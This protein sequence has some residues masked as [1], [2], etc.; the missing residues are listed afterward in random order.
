MIKEV[1]QRFSKFASVG[2]VCT[3]FSLTCNFVLLKYVHT[4]LIPTYI[5]VSCCS[6]FLS[7][8][9]NSTFTFKSAIN[10]YNLTAYYMVYLS[11]MLIGVIVLTIY[12]YLL[13]LEVWIY[14]FMV[15]PITMIWNFYFASKFL[16]YRSS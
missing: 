10:W 6:I 15:T 14:P 9:L 5:G 16:A 3:F 11:S 13:D 2:V 8:L 7:F 1:A 4:L 12:D